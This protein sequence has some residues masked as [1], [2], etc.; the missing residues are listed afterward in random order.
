MQFDFVLFVFG[1]LCQKW[2]KRKRF[3][4]D[5]PDDA[6]AGLCGDGGGCGNCRSCIPVYS[7]FFDCYVPALLYHFVFDL[8]KGKRYCGRGVF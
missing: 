8:G 4:G 6:P 3:A 1:I 2:I 7:G 5:L